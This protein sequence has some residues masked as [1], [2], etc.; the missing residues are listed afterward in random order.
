MSRYSSPTSSVSFQTAVLDQDARWVH[1]SIMTQLLA[2]L[3][4][5]DITTQAGRVAALGRLTSVIYSSP[6]MI[7]DGSALH[8]TELRFGTIVNAGVVNPATLYVALF[9]DAWDA[10]W[11][12]VML[13]AGFRDRTA[14]KALLANSGILEVDQSRS[15]PDPS[16]CRSQYNDSVVSYRRAIAAMNNNLRNRIG[17]YNYQTF[18]QK[19]NL[20]WSATAPFAEVSH[21]EPVRLEPKHDLI[22]L[23]AKHSNSSSLTPKPIFSLSELAAMVKQLQEQSAA[24]ED[25]AERP[26]RSKDSQSNNTAKYSKN[27]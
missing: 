22:A 24:E 4:T 7:T 8:P 19:Y 15:T 18:E 2:D 21:P 16:E 9:C 6:Y 11:T 17:V 10:Y 3:M 5:Y 23:A 12:Q 20:V 13:A 1:S 14:E 27:V 26:P 25:D